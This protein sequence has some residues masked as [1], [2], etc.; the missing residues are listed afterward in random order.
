MA[1][2]LGTERPI[3]LFLGA[4]K[5]AKIGIAP[6]FGIRDALQMTNLTSPRMD[7]QLM[8][9]RIFGGLPQ[10]V[11]E[12]V[13]RIYHERVAMRWKGAILWRLEQRVLAGEANPA[14]ESLAKLMFG[15]LMAHT[16]RD[17]WLCANG[18]LRLARMQDQRPDFISATLDDL[19]AVGG[20]FP[21]TKDIEEYRKEI[22]YFA[23]RQ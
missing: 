14:E 17:E 21:T 15:V 20:S 12:G 2:A 18:R 3:D 11:A 22:Q 9:D 19:E 5:V 7:F 4:L 13:V 1:I 6:S 8:E 10:T 23:S 16:M